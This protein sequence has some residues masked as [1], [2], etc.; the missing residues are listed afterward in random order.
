MSE[1]RTF[2]DLPLRIVQL[3]VACEQIVKTKLITTPQTIAR[4]IT[5]LKYV[6]QCIP[7]NNNNNNNTDSAWIVQ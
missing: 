5:H 6:I 3:L 4:Q 2:D 7:S 1:W